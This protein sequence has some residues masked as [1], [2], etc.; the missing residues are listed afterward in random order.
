M[1]KTKGTSSGSPITTN[2]GRKLTEMSNKIALC[3][4]F[5]YKRL[6][7]RMATIKNRNDEGRDGSGS[8]SDGALS[9]TCNEL[10]RK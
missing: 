8:Y 5:P 7:R 6:G 10:V 1:N 3:I 9:K 2:R 4:L